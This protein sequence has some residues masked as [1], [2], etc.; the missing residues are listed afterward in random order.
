MKET[1]PIDQSF[2]TQ[3]N[4]KLETYDESMLRARALLEKYGSEILNEEY[5][6]DKNNE[7]V[8]I[9]PNR[10]I[11]KYLAQCSEDDKE[12]F[13]GHGTS[14]V[15]DDEIASVINIATN[16]KMEGWTS[17]VGGPSGQARKAGSFL[18]LSPRGEELLKHNLPDG[19]MSWEPN[20]GAIAVNNK[21]Y[22]MIEELKS[23]FPDINFIK[24]NELPNYI[25]G[26]KK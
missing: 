4:D 16:K 9:D 6:D 14:S 23:M 19:K 17:K 24:A 18:I 1:G 5:F 8:D 11:Q 20:I 12:Q 21:L 22:P 7:D 13:W 26:K 3:P 15:L 10:A 25:S 2:P